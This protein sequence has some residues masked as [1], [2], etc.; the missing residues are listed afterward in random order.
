VSIG[1]VLAE[2][3]HQRGFTVAEVSHY[4][5]IREQ[6][7]RAIERDDYLLSGSDSH[8]RGDIR[9][10]ATALGV[11]PE[12]LIR[13]FDETYHPAP[14]LTGTYHSAP[15]V[16]KASGPGVTKTDE[17]RPTIPFGPRDQ[18]RVN[19]WRAARR[20][21][22]WVPLVVVLVLAGLGFA[23][24]HF[25]FSSTANPPPGARPATQPATATSASPVLSA[26]TPV[27]VVAYGPVGLA[28]GD[29]PKLA[30]RAT[31]G[32]PATAWMTASYSTAHFGNRRSGTGLLLDMGHE[33]TITN[34]EV[35]LG[36]V[37]GTGFQMRA[38]NTPLLADMPVVAIAKSASGPLGVRLITPVRARYV[39]IWFTTLPPDASGTF[40]AIVYNIT[41]QGDRP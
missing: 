29:N 20:R 13:E 35:T 3:R 36:T 5:R 7:I 11:D 26:L 39:L 1:E 8:A 14:E 23:A 19:R 32:N 22:K 18:G 34:A 4:T 10:I 2:A 38:G 6:I 28:D 17:G 40:Q 27:S 41:I 16:T 33:V 24:Y 21:I 25:F 30:S 9:A 37:P 12:P 15:G 31:D